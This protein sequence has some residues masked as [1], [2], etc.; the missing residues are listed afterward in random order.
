MRSSPPPKK[1]QIYIHVT[2]SL[3]IE[4]GTRTSDISIRA[5]R[6]PFRCLNPNRKSDKICVVHHG[7]VVEE[8][9]HEQLLAKSDSRY[10]ILV[11]AA[12]GRGGT[13][14]G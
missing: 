3:L 4:C 7:A 14:M 13:I 10:K 12:E 9:S 11:D 8:G 6:T 1:K 5:D 2:I